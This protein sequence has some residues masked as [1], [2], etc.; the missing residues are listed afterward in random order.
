MQQ[1]VDRNTSN[2]FVSHNGERERKPCWYCQQP[3]SVTHKCKVK[4]ATHALLLREDGED[5]LTEE[6]NK[7]IDEGYIITPNSPKQ[8]SD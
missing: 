8:S 3:W 5:S 4:K 6:E 7:C 1:N 2:K